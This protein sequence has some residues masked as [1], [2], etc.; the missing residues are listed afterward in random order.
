MN[1]S[2]RNKYNMQPHFLKRWRLE[3]RY[4]IDCDNACTP[5]KSRRVNRH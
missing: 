4:C 1:S 3:K 5:L 2:N